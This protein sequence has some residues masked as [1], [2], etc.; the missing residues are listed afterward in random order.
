M[1]EINYKETESHLSD[2]EGAGDKSGFAQ[3]YLLYGEE[4]LYKTVL[5]ELL[6][7]M[8]PGPERSLQYDPVEGLDE[9]IPE[10]IERV[11]TFSLSPGAKVVALLDSRVFHTK[12]TEGLL[13]GKAKEAHDKDDLKMA[14]RYFMS[15]LGSLSLT[16]DDLGGK[17][18]AKALKLDPEKDWGEEWIESIITYAKENNLSATTSLGGSQALEIAVKKG[19]PKGHHL[20]ITTDVVDKRQKLFRAIKDAGVVVNCSVPRGERRADKEAQEAVLNERARAILS[21]GGK[22]LGRDA[23]NLLVNMT[24][25]DLRTF[26]SGLEKLISYTGDRD[27]ITADDVVSVLERTKKD[28][29]FEFTNAVSDRDCESALFYVKSLLADDFHPLQLLAAMTNVIRRLLVAKCFTQ[30]AA[31]SVWHAGLRYDA[32]QRDV[33][34]RLI[35]HDTALL[36]RLQKWEEMISGD[37]ETDEKEP[38]QKKSKKKKK[39]DTDLTIA[40]NPN[41]PFPIYQQLRKSENYTRED[42]LA[43]LGH[44]SDAD[45]RMKSTTIDPKLVLEEAILSICLAS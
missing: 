31:G 2:V 17:D 23:Y 26:S 9:N 32:F 33:L 8:I 40:K 5:E 45:M 6:G 12:Q 14:A 37:A 4:M 29:V 18:R 27:R 13:I 20:I 3:V 19:F 39:P 35:D 24:G 10:A 7:K 30:S 28:P 44:L 38:K 1:A 41:N 34:P 36:E 15:V 16:L 43:S 42:L 22:K 11:N 21:Q 25:F